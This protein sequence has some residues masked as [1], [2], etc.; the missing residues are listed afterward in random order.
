MWLWIKVVDFGK[1]PYASNFAR[2]EGWFS[3]PNA[4]D[5]STKSTPMLNP[6]SKKCFHFS[7][8][9]TKHCFVLLKNVPLIWEAVN[10]FALHKK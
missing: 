3:T 8:I 4:F 2:S 5:G 1:N 6:L 9:F 10:Q 7:S